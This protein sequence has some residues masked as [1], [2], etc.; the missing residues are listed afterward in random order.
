MNHQ[1]SALPAVLLFC[2]VSLAGT[3]CR[4]VALLAAAYFYMIGVVPL[5]ADLKWI[6]WLSWPWRPCLPLSRLRFRVWLITDA[7]FLLLFLVFFAFPKEEHEHGGPVVVSDVPWGSVACVAI[8]WLA[9]QLAALVVMVLARRR[10]G[11]AA[12]DTGL[13]GPAVFYCWPWMLILFYGA[14]GF[15]AGS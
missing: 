5:C 13:L 14:G 6:R 11:L 4:W 2:A 10:S 15:S 8:V 12:T 3:Y 7:C 9:M 1:L